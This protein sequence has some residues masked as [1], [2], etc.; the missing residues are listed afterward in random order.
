MAELEVVLRQ[1]VQER[2]DWKKKAEML[3]NSYIESMSHLKNSL[4]FERQ[5]QQE[6]LRHTRNYFEERLS[7]LM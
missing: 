3:A 7:D 4:E 6:E 1:T 5:D 2:D